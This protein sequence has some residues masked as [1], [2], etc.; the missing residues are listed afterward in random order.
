MSYIIVKQCVTP[1][2]ESGKITFS[3]RDDNVI[4]TLSING[5]SYSGFKFRKLF[6]DL[7]NN[8][9]I[10]GKKRI[11]LVLTN[12]S[13]STINELTDFF[14]KQIIPSDDIISLLLDL[15]LYSGG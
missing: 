9:L 15:G 7:E 12:T 8:K 11:L 3:Y 2:S 10:N 13:D 1:W 5:E 14:M 4:T 6:D